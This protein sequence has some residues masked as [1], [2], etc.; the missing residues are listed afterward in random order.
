MTSI[1][2][3]AGGTYSYDA[4]GNMV[5]RN[6]TLMQWNSLNLPVSISQDGS[7]TSQFSYAPDQHRYYQA[8]LIAGVSETT[9]YV[10]GYEAW[11]RAGVTTFR[12]HLM[13]YG[14]E[15]A[16]VD[17][18]N[19]GSSVNETVSYV[20]T[21]H[22]GSVDVITN[23]SGAV[24]AD[25]SFS[26]WGGRR[27]P[28]TWEAP[29]GTAEIQTD[30]DA[31]R[32]GFTHQEM[33]DNVNLIH[34]N[35]RVYDPN[36]GRFLSVDPIFEF[37][38]NTQS[39]N[40]YSYVLNNL[41][42]LTDP[43]GYIVTCGSSDTNCENAISKLKPGETTTQRVSV[44]PI[45][46]RITSHATITLG[47]SKGGNLDITLGNG[48]NLTQHVME[49]GDKL[50]SASAKGSFTF[51]PNVEFQKNTHSDLTPAMTQLLSSQDSLYEDPSKMQLS[52]TEIL[53]MK[54]NEGLR[55]T[56]YNDPSRSNTYSIGYGTQL[57]T[58]E[59]WAIVMAGGGNISPKQANQWFMDYVH[60]RIEGYIPC[61]AGTTYTRAT[62][63][64][65]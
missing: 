32:Y 30:H 8:A 1:T 59:K 52:P 60:T 28:G 2:G 18:T 38:T 29:V 14:R 16:E 33:L 35:G 17:L 21:D 15:V 61:C 7:N 55:L 49:Q 50:A 46:S 64:H 54:I 63:R 39:L 9:V 6:G 31:D 40:P 36:L 51:R 56:Y 27:E 4:D 43:T 11:T 45:G 3:P 62:Q 26:A 34:M 53:R 10:G 24:V 44:T 37:P 47:L 58:P 12:H 13:A 65:G 42:S 48:A 20:L 5:N 19:S 57:D 22:L 41:L 25:M 23:A